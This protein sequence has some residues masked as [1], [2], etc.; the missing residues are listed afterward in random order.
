MP[1]QAASPIA[2]AQCGA[3][4]TTAA[5]LSTA[6]VEG[7]CRRSVTLADLTDADLAAYAADTLK[8]KREARDLMLAA[9]KD[10]VAAE[11]EIARRKCPHNPGDVILVEGGRRKP[12]IRCVFIGMRTL[13][14]GGI[15]PL[16]LPIMKG[17]SLSQKPA[18]TYRTVTPTTLR[19]TGPL[20]PGAKGEIVEVAK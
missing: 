17:G 6:N 7:A 19:W 4:A 20:T 3:D 10:G 18:A 13:R 16:A 9:N 11:L 12:P 2:D 8:R 15:E 1:H 14:W 5:P